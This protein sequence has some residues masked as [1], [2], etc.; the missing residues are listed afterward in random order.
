MKPSVSARNF[1]PSSTDAAS[2]SSSGAGGTV[3]ALQ[4]LHGHVPGGAM[5]TVTP[6]DGVSMLKLSSK[7][8]LLIDTLP[9]PLADQVNDQF[10]VPVAG[11]QVVPPLVETSTPARSPPPD[12]TA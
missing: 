5:L 2:P 7:A 9:V 8:R 10:E 1:V 4:M 3:A 12:S 6:A 11:D